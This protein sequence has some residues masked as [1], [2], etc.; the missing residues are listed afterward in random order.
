MMT[1]SANAEVGNPGIPI[2]IP[3]NPYMVVNIIH[4]DYEATSK[5]LKGTSAERIFMDIHM[6][7]SNFEVP[8]SP[9]LVVSPMSKTIA[10]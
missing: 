1:A 3:M 8:H 7:L 2:C 9:L 6:C 4:G 10:T 5:A